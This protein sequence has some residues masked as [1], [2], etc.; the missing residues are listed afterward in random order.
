MRCMGVE[1]LVVDLH[2]AGGATQ[3]SLAD[4][5][6]WEKQCPFGGPSDGCRRPF[7]CLFKRRPVSL[8]ALARV[9]GECWAAINEGGSTCNPT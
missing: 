4:L 7:S 2:A 1:R 8:A 6:K 5:S 9:A 3:E